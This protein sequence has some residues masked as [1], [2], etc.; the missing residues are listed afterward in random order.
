M[1]LGVAEQLTGN[2]CIEGSRGCGTWD[3]WH[4]LWRAR[5]RIMEIAQSE[6][7]VVL[8]A[9]T[10]ARGDSSGVTLRQPIG[11][12][13]EFEDG[14][15]RPGAVVH[16]PGPRLRGGGDRARIGLGAGAILGC[17]PGPLAQLGERRLDKPEVTGSSPVRPIQ[18]LLSRMM[19]TAAI[20]GRT[21]VLDNR[22]VDAFFGGRQGGRWARQTVAAA[23]PTA[24]PHAAP[25]SPPAERADPA[26]TLR[27][28]AKLH[29]RGVV[30][31]AEF[32]SLRAEIQQAPAP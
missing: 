26:E 25:A 7:T 16:R 8:V 6:D 12:V 11:Y 10:E 13:Y 3:E 32:E 21:D 5:L 4:E 1:D 20:T 22:R 14:M 19:R 27:E 18:M 30:T 17:L 15:A 24:A 28:L 9:C 23:I 31:D 29:Q 2:R